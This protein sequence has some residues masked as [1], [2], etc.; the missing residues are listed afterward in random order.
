VR[1][2]WFTNVPLDAVNRHFGRPTTGSGFWMHALIE[3]LVN[4]GEVEL[5]V[6]TA[7]AGDPPYR[8]RDGAVDYFN[9]PQN[10]YLEVFGL[11][12]GARLSR[13]LRHAASIVDAWKP[14]LIHVHGTERFFG[15][16]RARGLTQAPM[17][18]SLQGIIS[19]IHRCLWGTMT[20]RDMIANTTLWDLSR[21]ATLV[22]DSRQY[23]RQM[24][25]E[26]E[27]LES[28]QAVIGRTDWDHAHARQVNPRAPYFHVDE[29]MRPEFW[30]AEPW[31]LES[32]R[33]GTLMT[34]A[35]PAPLKGLPV[36]LEAT[37]TLRSWG[38]DVRLKVA[39]LARSN[40]RGLSKY[41]FKMIDRLQ[42]SDAVELLGWQSAEQLV[43]HMRQSHCFVAPSLIENSSNAVCEA[44]LFG[45]PCVA[46]HTGGLPTLVDHELTGLLFSRGDSAML[47]GDIERLLLD[48]SLA[49]RLGN[50]ARTAARERHDPQK[51]VKELITAYRAA[52][53][54]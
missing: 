4:S 3:P 18:V 41:V 16:V 40:P 15:L 34:T 33:R 52:T 49:V 42:L 8:F 53:T 43:E 7:A 25:I 36:L 20:W 17:V 31:S 35:S 11:F 9:I 27:V 54:K 14:D 30:N 23:R 21:N 26:R 10:K 13:Y 24:R 47:A 19:E 39:G 5:A 45:M 44:Q 6:V 32:V 12:R 1:V 48:A 22:A 37:A 50:A 38:H 51:I 46:S 2:L 28:A 29:M